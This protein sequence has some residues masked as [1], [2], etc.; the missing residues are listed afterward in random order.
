MY[1]Y[2]S[3]IILV[4]IVT[5]LYAIG[6]QAQQ[7]P[8]AGGGIGGGQGNQQAADEEVFVKKKREPLPKGIFIPSSVTLGA[9]AAG[10]IAAQIS[11]TTQRYEFSADIDFHRFYLVGD[12]GFG[13]YQITS[14]NVNYSNSGSYYR[15]GID[16][17]FLKTDI[18]FNKAYIGVRYAK[19]TLNDELSFLRQDSVYGDFNYSGSNSNTQAQWLEAVVG[20]R[21]KIYGNFY[22]G[23]A[24][25][26]MFRRRFENIQSYTPYQVPGYGIG[27]FSSR[28]VFHYYLYYRIPFREKVLIP[29]KKK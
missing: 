13:N 20:M 4:L 28:W 16:V 18:D 6:A 14:P 12:Y 2:F 21:G 11:E 10:M 22:G 19:S 8:P 29:I 17:D 24:F 15:V 25:R 23:Y 5:M 27:Q 3:E 9:D 1:R 7:R 26:F